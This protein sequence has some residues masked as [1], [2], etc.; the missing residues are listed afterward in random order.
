MKT[1]I[2]TYKWV[3]VLSPGAVDADWLKYQR[4]QTWKILL[5]GFLVGCWG[6]AGLLVI[7]YYI[8]HTFTKGA[9]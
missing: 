6:I 9:I 8:V 1:Q 2:A 3:L 7:A 4:R 5:K